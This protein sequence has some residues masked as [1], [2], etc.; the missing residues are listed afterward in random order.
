MEGS[1]KHLTQSEVDAIQS[2]IE[3]DL[4]EFFAILQDE[5]LHLL[6]LAEKEGWDD[7]KLTE[8]VRVML[9]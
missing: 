6:V 3:D 7:H 4:T 9:E 5:I 8:M 1:E 2:P